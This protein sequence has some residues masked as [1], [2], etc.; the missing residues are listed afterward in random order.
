MAPYES[1]PQYLAAVSPGTSAEQLQQL[2][3]ERPDLRNLV[4]A[5]PNV[6]PELVGWIHSQQPAAPIPTAAPAGG[7][8]ALPV[9]RRGRGRVFGIVAGVLALLLVAGGAVWWFLLRDDGGNSATAFDASPDRGVV[10]NLSTFGSDVQLVPVGAQQRSALWVGGIWV[11]GFVADEQWGI[12]GVD[13]ESAGGLPLWILPLQGSPAGCSAAGTVLSCGSDDVFEVEG[14]VARPISPDETAEPAEEN[15]SEAD[16]EAGEDASPGARSSIELGDTVSDDV[17]YCA[18]GATVVDEAGDVV[19]DFGSSEGIFYALAPS[20][21]N[22]PWLFSD[23]TTVAAA[24]GGDVLWESDLPD[25]SAAV[26]GFDPGQEPSWTVAGSVLLVG[27][28]DGVIALDT[29]TGNELWRVDADVASWSA[30]DGVLL[31]SNGASVA[32]MEFPESPLPK[33]TDTGGEGSSFALDDDLAGPVGPAW[34]DVVNSTLEVP[35]S[36]AN[37][38]G[39]GSSTVSF[40]EGRG[41]TD[42]GYVDITHLSSVVVEGELLTAIAFVCEPADG[43][44]SPSV[45]AYDSGLALVGDVDFAG[46][47]GVPAAGLVVEGMRGEGSAVQVLVAGSG[48]G[49]SQ[50]TLFWDG[51]GF[52][53]VRTGEASPI[54]E[55]PGTMMT[56]EA[57]PKLTAADLANATLHMPTGVWVPGSGSEE[58]T[59]VD[60][61]SSKDSVTGSGRHSSNS[62]FIT[63]EDVVPARVNGEDFLFAPVSYSGGM[64]GSVTGT[65][66][67]ISMDNEAICADPPLHSVNRSNYWVEDISVEGDLVTCD[68]YGYYLDSDFL[69]GRTVLRFDG[70]QFTLVSEDRL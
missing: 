60:Y 46:G 58:R 65:L 34:E 40:S 26:N 55:D 62:F 54:W 49:S 28:P 5:H 6:Y 16:G 53:P 69:A 39:L 22:D 64:D 38:A 45:G 42:G 2:A 13:P 56:V 3:W 44:P 1:D 43:D 33:D 11:V 20:S 15:N 36:C 35:A 47:L 57:G 27:A 14:A 19:V 52:V 61:R 4:L 9:R 12:A 23:G 32:V 48:T 17:P 37:S 8:Q 67:A 70:H 29:G 51:G 59:F 50:V 24:E 31:V 68:I 63:G 66:C 25:G 7:A 30:G 18:K 41:D 10:V 21:K